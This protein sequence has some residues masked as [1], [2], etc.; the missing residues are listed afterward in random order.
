[1]KRIL[2]YIAL[3]L[4]TSVALTSC[5]TDDNSDNNKEVKEV[6][7]GKNDV[8]FTFNHKMFGEDLKY[9]TLNKANGN[10]EQL[11]VTF[12][13]YIISNFQ[14]TDDKGRV[15]TYPKDKGYFF[16]D[17]QTNDFK[18]T[19]KDVSAGYYTK[20]KFGLGV[21]QEKYLRGQDDQ[22]E[23]WD[24]C[25][26]HD[27]IWG[28]ITGYKFINYQGTFINGTEEAGNYQLH[29]GSHGSKL[30]NYKEV[31]LNSKEEIKVSNK[32]APTV[33]LNVETSLLL[34]STNKIV[35]KERQYIM[36]DKERAP[37]IMDNATTM[38]SIGKVTIQKSL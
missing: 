33:D 10:N 14:L 34:D 28:W 24:L 20:V 35:L 8:T 12:L 25:K 31:I 23:F 4:S 11:N 19:L 17:S 22:Q 21:D 2:S 15:Y 5:S 27:L 1:M 26:K 16:V 18:V 29:I 30:D 32:Y 38:Y 13:K 36:V 7:E 37:K 3:F 6:L 9:N